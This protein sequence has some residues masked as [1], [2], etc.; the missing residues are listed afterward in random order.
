MGEEQSVGMDL[1]GV[2]PTQR[3]VGRLVLGHTA[4]VLQGLGNSEFYS[5]IVLSSTII[6]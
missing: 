3:Q 4:S 6:V 1:I 5:I 2:D